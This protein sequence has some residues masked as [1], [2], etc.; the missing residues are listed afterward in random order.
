MPGTW[1]SD[2]LLN[3]VL[4]ARADG[5]VRPIEVLYLSRCR[6]RVEGSPRTLADAIMRSY[7]EESA[8]TGSLIADEGT[9]RDL[10][11]MAMLDGVTDP[12]EQAVVER[13][14]DAARIPSAR[15]EA[16]MR[17][18]MQRFAAERAAVDAENEL[19]LGRLALAHRP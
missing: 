3:L 9:L 18:A 4:V 5:E 10:V 19:R 17:E 11:T 16:I 12:A 6:A 15:V 7:W 1:R 2:Y 8:R 14:V 13:F